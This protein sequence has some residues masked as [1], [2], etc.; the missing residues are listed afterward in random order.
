MPPADRKVICKHVWSNRWR[1]EGRRWSHSKQIHVLSKAGA[2]AEKTRSQPKK[3]NRR[4][5]SREK[6]Q[7]IINVCFLFWV[8]IIHWEK[9]KNHRSSSP[10]QVETFTTPLTRFPQWL[11]ALRWEAC[12]DHCLTSLLVQFPVW[13]LSIFKKKTN[14]NFHNKN[15]KTFFYFWRLR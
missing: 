12:R 7:S 2:A 13:I 1:K 10:L 8:L 15:S 11:L 14:H 5:K 9:K 6:Y 4:R 3:I